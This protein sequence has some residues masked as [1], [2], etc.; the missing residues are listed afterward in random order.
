M[1]AINI[2]GYLLML[3]GLF[4]LGGSIISTP[5]TP[6]L[7][8][9]GVVLVFIGIGLLALSRFLDNRQKASCNCCKCTNCSLEHDHWSHATN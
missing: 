4:W 3:S 5:D 1:K 6:A 7:T 9:V 2:V 8:F